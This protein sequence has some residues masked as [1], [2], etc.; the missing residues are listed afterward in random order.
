SLT[1]HIPVIYQPIVDS[2]L[3]WPGRRRQKAVLGVVINS[4][5]NSA[6][7]SRIREAELDH[8][9]FGCELSGAVNQA[10]EDGDREQEERAQERTR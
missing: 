5:I 3:R 7:W 8:K 4:T 6:R 10:Q 2:R 9:Y 1:S